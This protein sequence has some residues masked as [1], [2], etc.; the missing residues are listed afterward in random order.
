MGDLFTDSPARTG[1]V[2]P[3]GDPLV[4]DDPV[5]RPDASPALL[6][7]SD[8]ARQAMRKAEAERKAALRARQREQGLVAVTVAVPE[9]WLE[10]LQ[11]ALPAAAGLK[12]PALVEGVLKVA[13]DLARARH[14]LSPA[15]LDR[16]SAAGTDRLRVTELERVL[17]RVSALVGAASAPSTTKEG[18][19]V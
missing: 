13:V 19:P 6:G 16:L 11:S 9:D 12:R 1:T 4:S 8:D 3:W 14:P 15:L 17:A 5:L 7:L 10:S 2:L 18:T